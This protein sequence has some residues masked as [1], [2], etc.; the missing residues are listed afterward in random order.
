[1]RRARASVLATTTRLLILGSAALL[2]LVLLL[3]F[4]TFGRSVLD[5]DESL[6]LL[7]GQGMLDGRTPY[8]AIWD[9]KPP[10]LYSVFAAAQ[11]VFGESLIAIRLLACLSVWASCVLIVR[12]SR[13]AFGSAPIGYIAAVVYACFSLTNGGLATNAEILSTPFVIAGMTAVTL[14]A[15]GPGSRRNRLLFSAGL[16]FGLAL[17]IKYTVVFETAMAVAIVLRCLYRVEM[18]RKEKTMRLLVFGTGGLIPWVLAIAVFVGAGAFPDYWYANFTANVI[19]SSSTP[20][21]WVTAARAAELQLRNNLLPWCAVAAS[22]IWLFNAPPTAAASR[23]P[24]ILV[25]AWL[26]A[27]AVGVCFTRRFYPHY[28]LQMLPALAIITGFISWQLVEFLAMTGW[29]YRVAP[30]TLMV[31]SLLF[32][33]LGPLRESL[34]AARSLIVTRRLPQDEPARVAGYVS[35]RIAHDAYLYVADY[36]PVLYYLVNARRPTRYLF[37]QFLTSRHFARVA[38]IDPIRELEFIILRQRPEYV[39]VRAEPQSSEAAFR[40]ALEKHLASHYVIDRTFT[41]AV[42]YRRKPGS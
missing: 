20:W 26:G 42:V 21:S 32:P 27:S 25:L 12:F 41:D 29:P 39:V 24:L 16:E 8:V 9:H 14:I 2:I 33:V 38:G 1:M 6:Y 7:V 31:A 13:T 17:Q 15:T 23:R 36:Q 35:E 19:H 37:P 10:G 3:R 22:I 18:F 28:S 11:W 5:P 40:A 30:L 4:G 34:K